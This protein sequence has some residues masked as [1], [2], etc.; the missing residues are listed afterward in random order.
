MKN[1]KTNFLSLTKSKSQEDGNDGKSLFSKNKNKSE[2]NTQD[3][4]KMSVELVDK[5]N[6][7]LTKQKNGSDESSGKQKDQA[8]KK[9]EKT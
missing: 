7:P 3:G 6:M 5:K 2:L 1:I 8:L 9:V 4:P